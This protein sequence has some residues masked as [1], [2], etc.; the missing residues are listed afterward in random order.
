VECV[1][2]EQVTG[3]EEPFGFVESAQKAWYLFAVEYFYEVE[4]TAERES[5]VPE[6]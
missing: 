3:L 6:A 2:L 4:R 5:R 1:I